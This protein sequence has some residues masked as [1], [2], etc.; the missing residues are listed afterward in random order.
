MDTYLNRIEGNK[1]FAHHWSTAQRLHKV[2]QSLTAIIIDFGKASFLAN[3]TQ[4]TSVSKPRHT[5]PEQEKSINIFCLGCI[6]KDTYALIKDLQM[7]LCQLYK[8]CR[9]FAPKKDQLQKK[10]YK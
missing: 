6:L 3:K 2:V 5:A 4:K 8:K 10:V 1:L 9:E 7:P